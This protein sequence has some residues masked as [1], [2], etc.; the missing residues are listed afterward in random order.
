MQAPTQKEHE[1]TE[2]FFLKNI[3]A[4]SILFRVVLFKLWYDNIIKIKK[5]GLFLN[6]NIDHYLTHPNDF[7]SVS[8]FSINT[9]HLT[10]F[11]HG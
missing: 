3:H 8:N 7:L 4:H 10:A 6:Y 2:K 9:Y 5:V 1:S 11:Y